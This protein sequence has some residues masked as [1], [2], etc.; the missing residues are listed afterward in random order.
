MEKLL[1]PLSPFVHWGMRASIAV[2]YLWHGFHNLPPGGFER[3]FT[4]PGGYAMGFIEMASGVA[5]LAGGFTKPI[6]TR[7]GAAGVIFF[8]LG[9]IILVHGPQGWDSRT[10]GA[11]FQVLMLMVGLYYLVKGNDV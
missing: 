2:T 4:M 5:L 6:V 3:R 9:A 8:M 11:E 10:G 1:K 7:L